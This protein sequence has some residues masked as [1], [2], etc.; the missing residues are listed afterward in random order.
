MVSLITLLGAIMTTKFC[1]RV[2]SVNKLMVVDEPMKKSK[3]Q[4][5]WFMVAMLILR[6]IVQMNTYHEVWMIALSEVGLFYLPVLAIFFNFKKSQVSLPDVR[7]SIVITQKAIS[8]EI[9]L[10]HGLYFKHEDS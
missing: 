1:R 5:F 6:I 7:V 4:R 8:E 9:M 10:S 3:I 2:K